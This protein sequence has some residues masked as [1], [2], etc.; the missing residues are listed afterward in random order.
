MCLIN[1][2][3]DNNNFLFYYK[4]ICLLVILVL[5]IVVNELIK[6]FGKEIG[7]VKQLHNC[8]WWVSL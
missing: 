4:F 3:E 2:D 8:D 6:Y 7:D 1:E 5:V